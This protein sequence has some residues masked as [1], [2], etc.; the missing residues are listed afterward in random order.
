MR[1]IIILLA[2]AL[3]SCSKEDLVQPSQPD[4]TPSV[5]SYHLTFDVPSQHISL[6]CQ[7]TTIGTLV[8]DYNAPI[9]KFIE[10]KSNGQVVSIRLYDDGNIGITGAINGHSFIVHDSKINIC[11]GPQQVEFRYALR[12]Q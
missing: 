6:D 10:F 3:S 2:I 9:G 5:A 7:S 12:E 1:V 8:A 11:D 4:A